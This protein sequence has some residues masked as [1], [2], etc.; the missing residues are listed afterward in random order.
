MS[1]EGAWGASEAIGR[2]EMIAFATPMALVMGMREAAQLRKRALSE[3][4]PQPAMSISRRS[5]LSTTAAT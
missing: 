5:S 2:F 1:C 4:S 3:T